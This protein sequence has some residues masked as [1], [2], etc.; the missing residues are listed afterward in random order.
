M[1][2]LYRQKKDRQSVA[3]ATSFAVSFPAFCCVLQSRRPREQPSYHSALFTSKMS[4]TPGTLRGTPSRGQGRGAIPFNTN[5]PAATGPSNIP[6]PVLETAHS[7][8]GASEAS[9]M[10]ASR[11]KQTKRDEVRLPRLIALISRVYL[12]RAS[13]RRSRHLFFIDL[14]P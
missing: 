10:S 1:I 7:T 5:S 11:Q 8:T 6:R 9:G 12:P 4:G 14:L 3:F 13:H 2:S